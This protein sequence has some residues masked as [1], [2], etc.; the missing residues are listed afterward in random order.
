MLGMLVQKRTKRKGERMSDEIR[1]EL[2]KELTLR[3]GAA[4]LTI[5]SWWLLALDWNDPI[6]KNVSQ[7]SGVT[8]IYVLG[9]ALVFFIA[10]T[11]LLV[12]IF[13]GWWVE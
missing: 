6:G 9:F 2:A 11:S 12:L 3:I 13:G 1:K 8:F 4:I 10:G 7:M 5:F